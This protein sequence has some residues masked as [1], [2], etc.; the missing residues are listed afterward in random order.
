[1]ADEDRFAAIEFALLLD[2][3]TIITIIKE[4]DILFSIMKRKRNL[5]WLENAPCRLL[6][7]TINWQCGSYCPQVLLNN[8]NRDW[9]SK[10]RRSRGRNCNCPP[11]DS[12][13]LFSSF[14]DA[15]IMLSLV[16][17]I[18]LFLTDFCSRPNKKIKDT[19]NSSLSLSLPPPNTNQ[20]ACLLLAA[21]IRPNKNVV[22]VVFFDQHQ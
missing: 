15:K 1:M 21:F 16:D 18:K 20:W 9:Y 5:F 22:V 6:N 4:Q 19:N 14:V 12:S 17:E 7:V 11:V 2:W 8:N 13:S 3:R 10:R